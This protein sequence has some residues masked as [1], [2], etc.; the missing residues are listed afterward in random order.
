MSEQEPKPSASDPNALVQNVLRES[1][2]QTTE[3]LRYYA[4][5][6]R[7]YN[8]RRQESRTY[9]GALRDFRVAVCGAARERDIDIRRP[10]ERDISRLAEIFKE[11]ARPYDARD[12]ACELSIPDRVPAEGVADLEQLDAEIRRWEEE[13]N[14]IGDDAQLA[15]VDLQ[16]MLQKQQQTLQMMSNVS[17][18][19][20]DTAMSVIRKMGG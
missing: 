4:E 5:R 12:V 9:L 2:L 1:Y 11:H 8:E 13:L 3:D 20:H 6:M 14:S 17:K 15:N 16:N 19:L 10:D 7:S 18:M